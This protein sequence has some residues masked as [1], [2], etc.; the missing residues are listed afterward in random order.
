MYG[1]IL[2]R[3]DYFGGI[4]MKKVF[5]ILIILAILTCGMSAS[6][7]NEHINNTTDLNKAIEQAHAQNKNM[8]LLFDQK[9]CYYCD[10]M[11]EKTLSNPDVISK[12]NERYITV[13]IDVNQ[14]SNIAGKYKVFGT[15]TIIFLDSNQKQIGKIEGY[16]DANEFLDTLKG[17]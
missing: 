15:P 5:F 6:F 9:D 3:T 12:L 17:I 7:A 2:F 16:V 1:R 14:Q 10:E 13:I 11:K 4:I 8:M